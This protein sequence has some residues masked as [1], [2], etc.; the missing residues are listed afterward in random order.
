MGILP[1]R[2]PKYFG[3]AFTL[4]L[5]G[6]VIYGAVEYALGG[7]PFLVVGDNPSSMSRTINYG[8]LTINFIAPFNTLKAGDVIVFHDP[9]GGPVLITHRIVAVTSCGGQ[10]CLITKGDNNLTNP[11]PDPWTVTKADYVSMVVL[12]VPFLGYISPSLWGFSGILVILPLGMMALLVLFLVAARSKVP[13]RVE[14]EKP[15]GG[16]DS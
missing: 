8:D 1:R 15:G 12:V 9:R 6:L 4:V 14:E 11:T 5:V 10:E 13:D 16:G 7:L 3:C 2:G